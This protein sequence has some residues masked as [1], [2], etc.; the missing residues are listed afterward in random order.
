MPSCD[1]TANLEPDG[2]NAVQNYAGSALV[3]RVW[4]AM[5][6]TAVHLMRVRVG[7]ERGESQLGEWGECDARAAGHAM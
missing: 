2:E 1:A 6:R 5:V 4:R 3:E 7:V